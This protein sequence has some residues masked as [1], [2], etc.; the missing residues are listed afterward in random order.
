V[1]IRQSGFE[2]HVYRPNGAE[3]GV[4]GPTGFFNKHGHKAAAITVP[5]NIFQRIKGTAIDEMRRLGVLPP[6][7]R[8]S[9]KGDGWITKQNWENPKPGGPC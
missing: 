1:N 9:I 8:G 5:D 3:A 7:G 4:F 2:I 6:K